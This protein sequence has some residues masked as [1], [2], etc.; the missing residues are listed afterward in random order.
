MSSTADHESRPPKYAEN[1]ALVLIGIASLAALYYQ[2]PRWHIGLDPTFV[3]PSWIEQSPFPLFYY[4]A[5]VHPL[6]WAG[7]LA[8]VIVRIFSNYGWRVSRR[9]A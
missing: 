6:A 3:H 7:I 5:A 9:A 1:S 2:V 8:L 4:M